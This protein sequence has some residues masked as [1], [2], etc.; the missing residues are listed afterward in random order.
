VAVATLAVQE[1][2]TAV[3]AWIIIG[4]TK[5]FQ[6]VFSLLKQKR[7]T[8]GLWSISWKSGLRNWARN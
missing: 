2:V 3:I 5:S 7:P 4:S 1:Q 6:V 8:T